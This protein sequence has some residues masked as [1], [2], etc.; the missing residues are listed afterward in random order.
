MN[1]ALATAIASERSRLAKQIEDCTFA[2][3]YIR[4]DLDSFD[5][6]DGD[7]KD[8]KADL[9]RALSLRRT[10]RKLLANLPA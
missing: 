4:T 3:D 2:I 9:R 7:I 8:L 5:H 1:N 10:A 6:A